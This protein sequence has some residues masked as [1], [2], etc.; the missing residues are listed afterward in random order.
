M[1]LLV[2]G[3]DSVSPGAAFLN[4]MTEMEEW[5]KKTEVLLAEG[6]EDGLLLRR[7]MI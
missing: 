3:L 7:K 6:A 4:R 1:P 2:H 5:A